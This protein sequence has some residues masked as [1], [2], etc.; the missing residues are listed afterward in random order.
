MNK[1]V[2]LNTIIDLIQ[3]KIDV[4]NHLCEEL[5]IEPVEQTAYKTALQTLLVD[6]NYLALEFND[7]E[8]LHMG[9]NVKEIR[10]LKGM[11]QA[12]VAEK[13]GGVSTSAIAQMEKN[14]WLREKTIMKFADIFNCSPG[15]IICYGW[16][17]GSV[18][19]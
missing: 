18:H 12:E 14:R 9:K 13:M 19:E 5:P 10:K 11:T 4:I 15:E 7:K 6:I 3:K 1:Y 8:S 17:K 2:E 16:T